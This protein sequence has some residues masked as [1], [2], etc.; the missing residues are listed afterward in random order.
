MIK[1]AYLIVFLAPFT[2]WSKQL[3]VGIIDIAPFAFKGLPQRGIHIDYVKEVFRLAKVPVI[4]SQLPYPRVVNGVSFGKLDFA[5]MFKRPTL[6]NSIQVGKSFGFKNLIVPRKGLKVVE[7]ENLRGLKVG[8]I[9]NAKYGKELDSVNYLNK[10]FLDSYEQS[11]KMINLKR[12]EAF[13]VS[14]PALHFLKL[15]PEFKSISHGKPFVLNTRY[16]YFYA[17]KEVPHSIIEKIQEANEKL[18]KDKYIDRLVLKY[19]KK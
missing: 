3:K 13:V 18:L 2:L 6:P 8:V 19:L 1:Y 10:V 7:L 16:N 11:F 14:E 5:I 4:L 12:L 15:Q 9:R 17:N